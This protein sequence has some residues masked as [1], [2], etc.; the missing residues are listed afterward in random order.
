MES[1]LGS[2]PIDTVPIWNAKEEEEE[3]NTN[4]NQI[5]RSI[6]YLVEQRDT[7]SGNLLWTN[8]DFCIHHIINKLD[9]YDE[10]ST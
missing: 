10:I 8:H 6:V 4:N 9:N 3:K 2:R 7:N 1:S 5:Q